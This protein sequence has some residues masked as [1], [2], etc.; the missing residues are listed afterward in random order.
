MDINLAIERIEESDLESLSSFCCGV[1]QIDVFFQKEVGACYKYRYVT[2][3]KC[4][5]ADTREIIGAFTLA[6]D[7]VTLPQDEMETICDAIPEYA[8][9]F[10]QQ[11]SYPAIN[12]SHLAIRKDMQRKG[13]GQKIVNF[14]RITYTANRSAGCQFLTVDALNEDGHRTVDFYTRKLGFI[15]LSLADMYS[16]TRRLYMPLFELANE[17]AI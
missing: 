13:I 9:I 6:N 10:A 11:S 16:P 17:I 1:N 5:N 12:I 8:A 14:V 3:Y 4:V 7:L 15:I 2:P